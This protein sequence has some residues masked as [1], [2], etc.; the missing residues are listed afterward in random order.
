VVPTPKVINAD[1][2]V[3]Q[4]RAVGIDMI[5][6]EIANGYAHKLRAQLGVSKVSYRQ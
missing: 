6:S 2:V 1:D 4:V 5:D 3:I